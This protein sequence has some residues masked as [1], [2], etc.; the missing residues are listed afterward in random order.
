VESE[1]FL[2]QRQEYVFTSPSLPRYGPFIPAHNCTN[3][4]LGTTYEIRVKSNGTDLES[5][6]AGR[7]RRRNA[8]RPYPL[9]ERRVAA[10]VLGVY[11]RIL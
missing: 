7:G 6:V 3:Q 5:A 1:V 11:S 9:I 4:V 2:P 10:P 8:R